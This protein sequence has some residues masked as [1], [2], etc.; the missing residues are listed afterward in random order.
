MKTK[1][2][3]DRLWHIWYEAHREECAARGRSWYLAH[4]GVSLGRAKA[5][6][7]SHREERNAVRKVYYASHKQELQ[8]YNRDRHAA[9]REKDNARGRTRRASPGYK[10]ARRSAHLLKRY[11]MTME[12][13]DNILHRQG[14]GCAI[15]QRVRKQWHVDH[16]HATGEVRGILCLKC[17]VALGLIGDDIQTARAIVNYLEEEKHGKS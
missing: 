14:G 2:E 9:H 8:K 5:W 17:N 10:I 12:D 3:R 4:R 11:G 1:E 6:D 13:F 16:N 15:C 7:A